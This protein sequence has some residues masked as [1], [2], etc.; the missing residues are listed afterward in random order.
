MNVAGRRQERLAEQIRDEV[1]QMLVRELKDPR[2]GFTTVTRVE[3]S[4]D[5]QHARVLVSVLGDAE[6]QQKT[7]EGLT[8]A[9]GYLRHELAHRLRLRRAPEMVLCWTGGR[10]QARR[11]RNYCGSFTKLREPDKPEREQ[12]VVS[13]SH[14]ELKIDESRNFRR[15]GDGQARWPDVPRCG[16]AGA[17]DSDDAPGRSLWDTGPLCHRNPAS[18]GG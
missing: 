18:L 10:R 5:L 15:S 12:A 16:G 2:I 6:A 9:S 4:P 8:S 13:I 17:K 14:V 1:A 7:L 11:S 3:L